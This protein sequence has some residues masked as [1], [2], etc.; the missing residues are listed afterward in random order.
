MLVIE[1]PKKDEDRY[2]FNGMCY[3][4]F[5]I[6]KDILKNNNSPKKEYYSKMLIKIDNELLFLQ[7]K[8]GFDKMKGTTPIKKKVDKILDDNYNKV[9]NAVYKNEN[10]LLIYIK[11]CQYE[12]PI[13]KKKSNYQNSQKNNLKLK[14]GHG[15]AYYTDNSCKSGGK[16]HC[17]SRSDMKRFC[18]TITGIT[19]LGYSVSLDFARDPYGK[20]NNDFRRY[21]A[22][23]TGPQKFT[24]YLTSKPYPCWVSFNYSGTYKG[25]RFTN[26][27]N[28]PVLTFLKT[29]NKILVHA[30]KSF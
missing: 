22:R 13:V 2:A 19:K 11:K 20:A 17:I 1:Y 16:E 30:T 10:I 5:S 25:T 7:R 23:N 3:S 15:Y 14:V 21:A 27:V 28:Q 9:K 29:K 26:T 8:Y 6:A 12:F 24:T 18:K 4:T